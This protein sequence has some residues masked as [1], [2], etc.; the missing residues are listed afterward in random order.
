MRLQDAPRSPIRR[1]SPPRWS[2]IGTPNLFR[3]LT[4]IDLNQ[5]NAAAAFAGALDTAK[6]FGGEAAK[7]AQQRFLNREMDRTLKRIKDAK[8]KG[9]ITPEQAN[10]LTSS[11]LKGGTGQDRGKDQKPS[12]DPAVQRAID[13]VAQSESGSLKVTNPN[14]TVEVKSGDLRPTDGETNFKVD[15]PVPAI[16][17][18][19]GFTA[20]R[21]PGPCCS[22]GSGA[23]PSPTR[24]RRTRSAATGASASTGTSPWSATSS[25]STS[26]P[27][28]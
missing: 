21:R 11:A 7:L 18:K 16:Q 3:D 6:F 26:T 28:A 20:G 22:R 5:K 12:S 19:S 15:P 25:G 13:R 27:S 2:S 1:A 23:P 9:L 10:S 8:A 24:R 17:Q 4:G 14:G